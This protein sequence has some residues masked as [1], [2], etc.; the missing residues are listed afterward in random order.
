MTNSRKK[1]QIVTYLGGFYVVYRVYYCRFFSE[2]KWQEHIDALE[3]L[4]RLQN[5]AKGLAFAKDHEIHYGLFLKEPPTH[6]DVVRIWYP[7]DVM[8]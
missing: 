4:I 6:H 3:E 5:I 8:V 2:C 7:K 1:L